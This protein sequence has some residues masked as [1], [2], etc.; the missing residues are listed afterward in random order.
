MCCSMCDCETETEIEVAR[1]HLSLL[2]AQENHDDQGRRLHTR[3]SAAR[4]R[5]TSLIEIHLLSTHRC[6]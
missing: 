6:A 1:Q 3:M 5:E 4:N 2:V